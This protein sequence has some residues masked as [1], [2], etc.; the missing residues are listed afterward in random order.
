MV[1]NNIYKG[2]QEEGGSVC[3]GQAE[4]SVPLSF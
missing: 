4:P 2:R 3:G 1:E